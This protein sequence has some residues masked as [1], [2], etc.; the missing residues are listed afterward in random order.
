MRT[1]YPQLAGG[2]G[3]LPYKSDG[4][5]LVIVVPRLLGVKM[6]GLVPLRVLKSKMISI[7][8]VVVPFRVLRRNTRGSKF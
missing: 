3:G 1:L 7:R 8:G 2:G 4:G 5:D 6:C